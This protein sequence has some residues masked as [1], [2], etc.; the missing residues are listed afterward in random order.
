MLRVVSPH[1][2]C[3]DANYCPFRQRS[4][5]FPYSRHNFLCSLLGGSGVN[6]LRRRMEDSDVKRYCK[7]RRD[8][9]ENHL[10]QFHTFTSWTFLCSSN[11]N[12]H[13]EI[14]HLFFF[15]LA[16]HVFPPGTNRSWTEAL[17]TISS[18]YF[19]ALFF[20]FFRLNVFETFHHLICFQKRRKI[21]VY[22]VNLL[23]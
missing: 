7:T 5:C 1:R 17:E 6:E 20:S 3:N 8:Q 14:Q 10:F 13:F 12:K 11:N 2:E 23:E 21:N 18:V 9:W 15:K 22:Q 4:S 16:T 19:Q